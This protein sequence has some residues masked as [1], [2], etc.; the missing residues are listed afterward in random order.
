MFICLDCSAGHRR[1]GVHISFV[2]SCDLDEWTFEQLEVM[3]ISGNANTASFFKKHGVSDLEMMSEKKYKT[4]AA[5]EYKKYLKKLLDNANN[6]KSNSLDKDDL[7]LEEPI[8]HTLDNLTLAS[9]SIDNNISNDTSTGFVQADPVVSDIALK[10]NSSSIQSSVSSNSTFRKKS[11]VASKRLGAR[12]LTT[13]ANDI[14]LDKFESPKLNPAQYSD[15]NI[16]SGAIC[17]YLS[18]CK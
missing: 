18:L 5:Q 10:E 15:K 2:R 13:N 17:C 4:K 9:N 3:K 16:P 6:L 8:I 12:K 1:L 14:K 11:T 7:S